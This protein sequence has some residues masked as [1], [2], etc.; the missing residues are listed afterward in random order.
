MSWKLMV[1]LLWQIA[2]DQGCLWPVVLTFAY[3]PPNDLALWIDDEDR[4]NVIFIGVSIRVLQPED[5]PFL[6]NTRPRI[7]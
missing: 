4:R 7:R 1:A 5:F 2:Y 6:R 3:I